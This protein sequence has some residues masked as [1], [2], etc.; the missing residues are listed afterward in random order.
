MTTNYLPTNPPRIA[1]V[2]RNTLSD[3]SGYSVRSLCQVD[4][5]P[6]RITIK[7]RSATQQYNKFEIEVFDSQRLEW[8]VVTEV[9]AEAVGRMG[10]LGDTPEDLHVINGIAYNLWSEATAIMLQ[11]RLSADALDIQ[12]ALNKDAALA[13]ARE[14]RAAAASAASW[15]QEPRVVKGDFVLAGSEEAARLA[16][17]YEDSLQNTHDEDMHAQELADEAAV[18][19]ARDE[20]ENKA[21]EG[22]TDEDR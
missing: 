5:L 12:H 8:F 16:Q 2:V 20:D 18:Q 10:V 17:E 13:G 6:A 22:E 9:D 1:S 11:S 19:A 3:R 14:D 4:G 15:Y 7:V 21:M